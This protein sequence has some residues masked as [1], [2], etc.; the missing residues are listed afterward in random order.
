[1]GWLNGV[2]AI[3]KSRGSFITFNFGVLSE[4]KIKLSEMSL[5][6]F[7]QHLTAY[8]AQF[9]TLPTSYKESLSDRP[10]SEVIIWANLDL[11]SSI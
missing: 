4:S 9:I 1:M 5:F 8:L 11:L 2:I 10:D 3:T 7:A 6:T